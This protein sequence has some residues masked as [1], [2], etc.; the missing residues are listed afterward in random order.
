MTL[1]TFTP[2]EAE[3]LCHRLDAAD[4]IASCFADTP[5]LAHHKAEDVEADCHKLA[6]TLRR[7]EALNAAALFERTREVLVEAVEGS[8]W[9]G[10]HDSADVSPQRRAAARRALRSAAEKIAQAFG[11][12]TLTTP[13]A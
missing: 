13:E 10:V 12:D 6:A 2:H 11:L 7:G 9:N 4:C 5:E 3:A 1:L 8:T